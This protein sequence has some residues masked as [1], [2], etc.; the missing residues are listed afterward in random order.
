[1]DDE[2]VTAAP[3]KLLTVNVKLLVSLKMKLRPSDRIMR[4]RV[5]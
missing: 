1:M 5:W 2:S 4:H 3:G